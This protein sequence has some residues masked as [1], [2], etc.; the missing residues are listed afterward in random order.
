MV[1]VVVDVTVDDGVSVG[2]VP[3]GNDDTGLVSVNV[4]NSFQ[5]RA[6]AVLGLDCRSLNVIAALKLVKAA[7]ISFPA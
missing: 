2:S 1:S 7:A 6:S 3:L 4:D 5:K